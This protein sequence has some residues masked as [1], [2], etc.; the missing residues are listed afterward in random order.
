MKVLPFVVP[1]PEKGGLIYQV[2]KVEVFYEKLHQH[3]EIQLSF[4]VNGEGALVVGDTIN[5]Y[6]KGDILVI[7]SHLPH[8]FKSEPKTS[9]ESHMLTLFFTKESFGDAFFNNEE[10]NEIQSFFERSKY[11]FKLNSNLEE[12]KTLFLQLESAS[13]LKRFIILLQLLN[14]MVNADYTSLS[15]FVYDKKYSIVEGDRMRN[16]FEFTMDN[17]EDEISLEQIARV[18]NMTKNAFCKYFKKRTNKTYI[19]FLNEFRVEK[20]SKLLKEKNDISIAEI[21]FMSGFRNISNFNRVFKSIKD[22]PPSQLK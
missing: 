4:I 2:D 5:N 11:G 12:L 1:K 10:L 22:K 17:Y 13:K 9:E 14:C 7:G 15:S 8:V 6:S 19:Q 3:E 21:A 20:A 18:A 16:V